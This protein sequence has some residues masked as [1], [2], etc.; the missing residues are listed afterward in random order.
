MKRKVLFASLLS[1]TLTTNV[2][3]ESYIDPAPIINPT[4]S[5]SKSILVDN[6]HG[7]TAGAAD[8]VIDGAFSDFARGL[9]GKGYTVKELRQNRAIAYEDISKYDV[10][11]IPEA[12]VPF[13]E[14][15]QNAITRYV[16]EGGSVFYIADH[17]NA[18]RN[19]NRIDSSEA[20]NGYRRGAFEDITKGMTLEEKSSEKMVGVKSSDWL[21]NNFGVRFRYNALNNITANDIVK[22]NDAMGITD[23]VN[24]VAMHAGSTIAITNPDIAK[25]LIYLPDNLT[26]TDKWGPSVDQGIYFGGGRDE[27]AYIAVSKLGLGKAAFIG[28]S[29]MVEDASP[30]YKREDS[31]TT[32]QTYNGYKEQNNALLL[33]NLV[34][35]L[36]KDENYTSFR[37]IGIQLDNKSPLLSFEVPNQSVEPQSEPWK[38]PDATYKWYD[39]STFKPGSY[40]Y[41]SSDSSGP[42]ESIQPYDFILGEIINGQQFKVTLIVNGLTPNTTYKDF[43]VGIYNNNGTQIGSF[44]L[45]GSWNSFGYSN[46]F[47]FT[48]DATGTAK[49]TFDA[50]TKVGIVGDANIRLKQGTTNKYTEAI[51][52]K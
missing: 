10:F 16:K 42:I 11:I 17:Y 27:G 9:A 44:N 46:A 52:I 40:G 30:K 7:Q 1:F 22:G 38:L 32:K 45:G 15:E 41:N 19:L 12:N 43:K 39:E 26:S 20:F 50:K 31:G 24:S 14:V 4:N 33:N 8:W 6:T 47:T 29:S 2:F 25:G 36:A 49:I 37:E 35:W 3:A 51:K 13:K 23:G 28:D 48:T 21:S 34:D 18:D 5:N